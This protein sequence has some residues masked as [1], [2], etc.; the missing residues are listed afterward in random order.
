MS[1]RLEDQHQKAWVKWARLHKLTFCAVPNEHSRRCRKC[2]T[3]DGARVGAHRKAMGVTPGV[4]DILIFDT[5]PSDPMARGLQLEFKA[6][7]TPISKKGYP[8]AKQRE[9]RARI[10]ACG[11]RYRV[12]YTAAEAIAVCREYG[13][14]VR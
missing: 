11:V 12:V 1:R 5:L 3:N 14:G 6:P 13:L 2:G 10:E 8:T 4:S 9:W 7:A